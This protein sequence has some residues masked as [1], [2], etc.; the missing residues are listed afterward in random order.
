[1]KSLFLAAA[2][3]AVLAASPTLAAQPPSTTPVVY[4]FDFTNLD[5]SDYVGFTYVAPD[6]ITAP[7]TIDA[8]STT[9]CT[10]NNLACT[11][12]ES[13]DFVPGGADLLMMHAFVGSGSGILFNG[14]SFNSFGSHVSFAVP[15]ATLTVSEGVQ[16]SADAVPEP[17]AWAL[18]TIGFGGLGAVLRRRRT[19]VSQ[20][21]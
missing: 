3:L 21:G 19:F 14:G 10:F 1:M 20:P 11:A 5:G 15:N 16:V 4:K 13:F 17:A 12:G 8:Q 6:F 9:G 7:T 2:A 18:M